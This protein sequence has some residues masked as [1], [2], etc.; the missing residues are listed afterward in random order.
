MDGGWYG[1][2]FRPSAR[3]VRLHSD[4]L[5]RPCRVRKHWYF[6]STVHRDLCRINIQLLRQQCTDFFKSIH[7]CGLLFAV[8]LLVCTLGPWVRRCD[9][10][11]ADAARLHRAVQNALFFYIPCRGCC[12][13][14]FSLSRPGTRKKFQNAYFRLTEAP[15]FLIII[16]K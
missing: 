1:G 16:E 2:A 5:L 8:V 15:G 7:S 13:A 9:G 4:S 6:L 10:A 11:P 14:L 12:Q 3:Q